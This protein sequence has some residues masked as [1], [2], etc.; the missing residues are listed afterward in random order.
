MLSMPVEIRDKVIIDVHGSPGSTADEN[1]MPKGEQCN[2]VCG[3][4]GRRERNLCH[5]SVTA[6]FKRGGEKSVYGHALVLPG[7]YIYNIKTGTCT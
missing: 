7:L 4:I 2:D 5:C 3:G 6:H 1:R